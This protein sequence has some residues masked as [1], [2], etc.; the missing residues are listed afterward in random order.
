MLDFSSGTEPA[1]ITQSL[2]GIGGTLRADNEH[3]IVEEIPLYEPA[4]EGQHL[5]VRLTKTGLTTKEVE[6]RLSKL[7]NLPRGAVGFAGMKDKYART[8]QTFS[9]N[10]GHQPAEFAEEA[11]GRIADNLP[12]TVEWAR[13][14]SNKLRTGHLLG[15]RFR[16]VISDIAIGDAESPAGEALKRAEQVCEQ[17]KRDGLPNYFGL[18]RF[19]IDGGNVARGSEILRGKQYVRDKWQRRFMISAYQSF[20][21]N[22]Y[23]D[24]RVRRGEFTRLLPGDVAKK[25][26]TGGMFDVE[27]VAA[28]QSRYAEHEISFTAP[29]YGSKMRPAHHAAGALE[30]EIFAA[31][32]IALDRFA[33]A[34][35]EGTRRLG[36]IL[37][38]DLT[39]ALID[40]PN[41]GKRDLR[42]D[43]T[44]PKGAYATVILREIMKTT[45]TDAPDEEDW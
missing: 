19:G 6:K 18:Q 27:D 8:T 23:L 20:L 24:A 9:L 37:T 31:A 39:V 25:Y 14:H 35:V 43:F 42:I 28:E 10:V 11:A 22:C 33:K 17:I 1:Y 16:I 4:D 2:P 38:P 32:D 13:F 3:F 34:R 45:P 44:L 7:F 26:A 29:M 5:Y 15:N 36:R 30:A 41:D 12:V 21:C 40:M